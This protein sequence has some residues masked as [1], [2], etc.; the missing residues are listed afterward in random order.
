[1]TFRF[2]LGVNM[3]FVQLL[4]KLVSIFIRQQNKTA[5]KIYCF[6]F[7]KFHFPFSIGKIV[8]NI[9]QKTRVAMSAF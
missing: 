7:R 9:E 3:Q 4:L 2:I 8:G 1:M 6:G 5:A